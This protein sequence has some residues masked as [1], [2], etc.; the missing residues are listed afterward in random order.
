MLCC[1]LLKSWSMHSILMLSTCPSKGLCPALISINITNVQVNIRVSK[2]CQF[3]YIKMPLWGYQPSLDC[4][5]CVLPEL[6]LIL[7]CLLKFPWTLTRH[8][9]LLFAMSL[10]AFPALYT[11]F[12]WG[13]LRSQGK[14]WS[15]VFKLTS[16]QQRWKVM[17]YCIIPECIVYC[18]SNEIINF[19]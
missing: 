10:S 1:R 15:P 5:K 4:L 12:S 19:N 14:L 18:N 3:W 8:E 2:T 11:C 9:L 16:N 7:L 13:G 17:T 6:L